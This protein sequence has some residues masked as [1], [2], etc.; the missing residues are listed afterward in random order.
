MS[1]VL[2]AHT[3]IT[4][5]GSAPGNTHA[6]MTTLLN[7]PSGKFYHPY[8]LAVPLWVGDGLLKTDV[9]G[10][11]SGQVGSRLTLGFSSGRDLPVS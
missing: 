7:R 8:T 5:Q 9:S 1:A 11:P 4:S 6:R 3:L 10:R 2:S